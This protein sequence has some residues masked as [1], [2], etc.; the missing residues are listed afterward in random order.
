M[1]RLALLR[2]GVGVAHVTRPRLV[3]E[4]HHVRHG[5]ASIPFSSAALSSCS[6][7]SCG[8]LRFSAV[9]GGSL[10]L[11]LPLLSG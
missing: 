1:L 10:S 7:K 3:L 5:R 4:P 9:L 8:P 2:V 6:I 11:S